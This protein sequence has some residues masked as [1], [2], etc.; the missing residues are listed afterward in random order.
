VGRSP[1]PTRRLHHA[2]ARHLLGED[3]PDEHHLS[4]QRVTRFDN[5]AIATAEASFNAVYGY[6]IRWKVFGSAGTTTAGDI[7]GPPCPTTASRR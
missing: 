1:R 6:D 2:T 5:G 4:C 3:R 7:R